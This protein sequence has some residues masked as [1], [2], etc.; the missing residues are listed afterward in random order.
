MKLRAKFFTAIISAEVLIFGVGF[1]YIV[2][3]AGYALR[4]AILEAG[5]AK[6]AGTAAELRA[7]LGRAAAM[8]DGLLTSVLALKANGMTDRDYLPALFKRTLVDNEGFYAIWGI[9]KKDAWDG[10]DD[11]F[12]RDPHFLPAGAFAPWAYREGD[13]IAVFAGMEGETDMS[14]YYEGDFYTI[15]VEQG[16]SLY[17]EPYSDEMVGGREVLMTTYAVPIADSSGEALGALGIDLKLD[18]LVP[19]VSGELGYAGANAR[20]VSAGGV[21]IADKSD[22]ALVGKAI[23]E[24]ASK[25]EAS[26]AASASES[27][28]PLSREVEE[29]GRKIARISVPVRV[30]GDSKPWVYVLTVPTASL[31]MEINRII[32]VMVGIFAL[33]ILSTGLVVFILSTNLAR[34]IASLC[35][36]FKRMEEGDLGVRINAIRSRDEVGEL[37]A[38]FDVFAEGMNGLA[39]GIARSAAVIEK[40]SSA[41]AESISRSGECAADIKSGIAGTLED[42]RAQEGALENS[43]AGTDTIVH[44][45]SALDESVGRQVSSINEAAASVEEMVGNIQSIARG[46]ESIAAE[47]KGLDDSGASGRE[48]LAA[49]L[50]AIESVVERSAALTE[51]NE[52]IESVAANTSLLAMNAAIEAAH[53]GEAGKGFAVVADEIRSLAERAKEQSKAIS[54]NVANIR[55][56][57]EAAASSSGLAREAFE[58]I[59]GRIAK[60]SRLEAE[61][62]AALVEQREGGQAVLEALAGIRDTTRSVEES[63][64]S[65][66]K[67]GVEVGSAMSSLAAAS[68]RVSERAD[69][70]ATEAARIEASNEDALRLSRENEG[71]VAE[72]RGEIAHFKT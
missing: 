43:R 49:V 6:A 3:R 60:V 51:A 62:S 46:S 67:A 42:M 47:I 16:K 24:V 72:L 66:A 33:L 22:P 65:M 54:A 50:E 53:A 31:Y 63:C 8:T 35:A 27:G 18:S 48:R 4:A 28:W 41:L 36:A 64:S 26:D 45:I 29:G 21:V 34:P 23:S 20:L 38:A 12:A 13:G 5:E 40:S 39:S 25:G 59:T 56:S 14:L 52:T 10:R 2:L 55:A 37:A 68:S 15:P 30:P 7:E 11:R 1:T 44:A 17:L 19:L 71:C 58:D 61:A 70:I 69:E 9:F 57:I 32:R